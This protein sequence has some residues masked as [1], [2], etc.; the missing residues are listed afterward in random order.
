MGVLFLAGP[1]SRFLGQFHPRY[2]CNPA[3]DR[4]KATNGENAVVNV[5]PALPASCAV[6]LDRIWMPKADLPFQIHRM[7]KRAGRSNP[8]G[9]MK[10]TL[11][12]AGADTGRC[13]SVESIDNA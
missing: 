3:L 8:N 4:N 2:W 6:E 5:F 1:A 10:R 11:R 12:S 7:P 13:I 9:Q